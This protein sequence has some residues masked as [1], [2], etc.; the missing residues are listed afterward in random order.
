[1]TIAEFVG[2]S[3]GISEQVFRP[4]LAVHKEVKDFVALVS[5]K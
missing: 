4:I 3:P 5:Q 2:H 1:M